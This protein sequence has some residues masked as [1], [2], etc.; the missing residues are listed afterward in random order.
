VKVY[1]FPFS[2]SLFPGNEG[3]KKAPQK[4]VQELKKQV[5]NEKN[6]LP[7]L[8]FEE[9]SEDS[10]PQKK[11][12]GSVILG[13]DHF[14][15]PL[16]VK[17][18]L[19]ERPQ[20]GIMIF[21]A[22]PDCDHVSQKDILP[23]LLEDLNIPPEK[24]V[25]VGVRSCTPAEQDYLKT[26]RVRVITMKNIFEHGIQN[27]CDGLMESVRG[28]QGLYVSIDVDVVDPACAP[29]TSYPEPGGF[30]SRELLYVIQR[31]RLL[32]NFSVADIVEANPEK[33]ERLTVQ[34]AAKLVR[35]LS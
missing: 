22:H 17:Q 7:S 3:V 23:L 35:E 33:E 21:D 24:I 9:I 29:G 34:L 32:K 14:I 27:V 19:Q 15:T 4:I 31:L 20:G 30:T 10:L 25:L 1:S 28:W 26:S 13:G 12:T 11:V 6:I 16:C 18:F 8:Q 5:M 2:S